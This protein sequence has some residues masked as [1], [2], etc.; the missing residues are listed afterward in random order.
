MMARELTQ[1]AECNL[2]IMIFIVDISIHQ[3]NKHDRSYISMSKG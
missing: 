1:V 2:K 3:I